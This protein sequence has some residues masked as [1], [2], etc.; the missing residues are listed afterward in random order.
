MRSSAENRFIT[1]TAQYSLITLLEHLFPLENTVYETIACLASPDTSI[2][3]PL[4]VYRVK[5]MLISRIYPG[6]VLSQVAKDAIWCCIA[7]PQYA[8]DF[9][10]ALEGSI[11]SDEANILPIRCP[12]GYATIEAIIVRRSV[13]WENGEP[14]LY[15]TMKPIWLAVRGIS[16]LYSRWQGT[17]IE[18]LIELTR[19]RFY[20]LRRSCPKARQHYERLLKIIELD[21][22]VLR[23]LPD[24][25]LKQLLKMIE[26]LLAT[27]CI[28]PPP[29]SLLQ[30]SW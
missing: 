6:T 21:Q 28:E 16:P 5:D 9:I 7:G 19:V 8:S 10:N 17:L 18:I 30:I 1:D 3:R 20:A 22:R 24:Y 4:G 26:S 14:I 29:S 25:L 12:R 23:H 11:S 13:E 2:I 15:L 27:G